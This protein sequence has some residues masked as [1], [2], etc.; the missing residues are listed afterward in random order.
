MGKLLKSIGPY[1]MSMTIILGPMKIQVESPIGY[2][3]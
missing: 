1:I 3:D 2:D